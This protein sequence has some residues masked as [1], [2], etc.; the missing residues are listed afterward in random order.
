M[1]LYVDTVFFVTMLSVFAY[2]SLERADPGDWDRFCRSEIPYPLALVKATATTGKN[3]EPAPAAAEARV[4]VIR[5][6]EQS[7]GTVEPVSIPLDAERYAVQTE[8]SLPRF[9]P[10]RNVIDLREILA[11]R[12]LKRRFEWLPDPALV[13]EAVMR[14]VVAAER[15]STLDLPK[16]A[17]HD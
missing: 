12:Y 5:F 2:P 8:L 14:S 4:L 10:G 7:G 13:E 9:S 16:G 15:L 6:D 3:N 11:R 17:A 1:I